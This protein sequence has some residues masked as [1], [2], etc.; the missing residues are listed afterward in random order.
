MDD[1]IKRLR[2]PVRPQALSEEKRKEIKETCDLYGIPVKEVS[3]N[4]IKVDGYIQ[5]S[6]MIAILE[7]LQL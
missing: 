2:L 4:G 1:G 6:E 7:L 5:Y 3:V